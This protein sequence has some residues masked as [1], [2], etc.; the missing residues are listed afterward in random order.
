MG[1]QHECKKG[2]VIVVN[3]VRIEVLRG[4]PR[5][6]ISAP[7]EV[8]IYICLVSNNVTAPHIRKC[9]LQQKGV[10]EAALK[11]SD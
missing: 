7:P 4:S 6:E 1:M 10:N 5:L 8:P 3:G 2:T 9:Q 11:N